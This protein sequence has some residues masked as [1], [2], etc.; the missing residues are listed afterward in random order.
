MNAQAKDGPSGTAEQ[1]SGRV[2]PEDIPPTEDRSP[3]EGSRVDPQKSDP[4]G[5]P[6]H[7]VRKSGEL[8]E[9]DDDNPD[10]ASD[11]LL[12]E[13]GEERAMRG[14]MSGRGIRYEPE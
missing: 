7:G 14:G 2:G 6:I 1:P 3:A 4:G 9:E 12:P 5:A 11:E 13:D 8:P 10:Q